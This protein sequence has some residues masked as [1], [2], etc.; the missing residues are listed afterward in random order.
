[1]RKC[2]VH[3]G[4]HKTGTTSLQA[5]LS[6][7]HDELQQHGFLY[8]RAGRGPMDAHHNISMEV[9]GGAR[10][11]PEFGT[12]GDLLNEI[13]STR[14]DIVISSEDLCVTAFQ[15]AFKDLVA[16]LRRSGLA[17]CFVVYLRNQIDYLRSAYFQYLKDGHEF[18]LKDFLRA[19][20]AN[21]GFPVSP[22]PSQIFYH[23]LLDHLSEIEDT[24]LLVYSYDEIRQASVIPH[25]LSV[26]G[27]I[28]QA[29]GADITLRLNTET[30]IEE[31]FRRFYENRVERPLSN[32]E[33]AVIEL[34][35]KK[36]KDKNIDFS[37]RTK[38]TIIEAC[39]ESN[40]AVF[41]K[42]DVPDFRRMLP[43]K[44]RKGTEE[45]LC[46]ED[47]FS[48]EAQFFVH[49]LAA[50]PGGALTSGPCHGK[51]VER[52]RLARLHSGLISRHRAF[53]AVFESV[54]ASGCA[55]PKIQ[56]APFP[57]KPD[58]LLADYPLAGAYNGLVSEYG[59]LAQAYTDLLA[60]VAERDA[61]LDAHDRLIAGRDAL[62]GA[63]DGLIV[64]RDTLLEAHN[65]LIAEREALLGA[66]DR[67][68]AERDTLLDAHDRLIA[69]RDAL[70]GAHDGLI[71]ERDTLLEAHNRLIRERDALLGA[72]DGLIVER[73]TLLDAHH[74]LIAEREALLGAHDGLIVERDT[75][76]DAHNHLIAE[77]EALLVAHDGL[78]AE[79]DTLLEAH[80]RLIAERE[81]LLGAHDG[82][83][84]ERDTLLDAHN[85]LIAEREAL[86]GAH[87]GL[88][89]ER[90]TLLEAHNRLIAERQTLLGAHDGL[91]VERDTLLD[92][93]N[94][95]LAERNALLGAHNE[96]LAGREALLVIHDRL[97]AERDALRGIRDHLIAERDRLDQSCKTA[98]QK[99]AWAMHQASVE[100]DALQRKLDTAI[101]ERDALLASHSWRLTAPL[102][103]LRRAVGPGLNSFWQTSLKAVEQGRMWPEAGAT[104]SESP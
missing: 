33:V 29:L 69:G 88:I 40:K 44:P 73:D 67:L 17:V 16:R 49:D 87:D 20:L 92:A 75:L 95:L 85:R 66:H 18:P 68:I 13:D 70:L 86:L 7:R 2:L 34:I 72:H 28:P 23:Q 10:F 48:A 76:L 41:G 30:A 71:V 91:I 51:D 15:P 25:F 65:R 90:D 64:E 61:L 11:R 99:L 36:L 89:V 35:F 80:N 83:I 1:M 21:P 32:G 3:I 24:R 104:S 9:S 26:L 84:V 81:A 14:N 102:R 22:Q 54:T 4:T 8:P 43:G 82:L 45:N 6:S 59:T 103:A 50:T 55:D 58:R 60:I 101:G 78:I 38:N 37:A 98:T 74:H 62:L 53:A 77:R 94:G 63:H 42:Y 12:I 96:L 27:L 79:R 57:R 52:A 39:A 5:V 31:Q 97:I 19:V 100:R 46:L 47:I 56:P 93:H